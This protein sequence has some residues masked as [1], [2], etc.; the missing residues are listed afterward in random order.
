M[1]KRS[2]RRPTKE[3]SPKLKSAE[4]DSNQ[5]LS[6]CQR[7]RDSMSNL[8]KSI[9]ITKLKLTTL[10]Y[11]SLVEGDTKKEDKSSKCFDQLIEL[12]NLSQ[13]VVELLEQLHLK[14]SESSEN[15]IQYQIASQQLMYFTSEW[16]DNF[17]PKLNETFELAYNQDLIN[18]QENLAERNKKGALR[19]LDAE[20]TNSV[21]LPGELNAIRTN[22]NLDGGESSK[23][24][25]DA[26]MRLRESMRENERLI[27]AIATNIDYTRA[28]I[29]TIHDSL[30][31]TKLN[32]YMGETNAIEAVK[33]LR[34]SRFYKFVCYLIIA[35]ILL[36]IL[37]ILLRII[38]II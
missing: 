23:R 22:N 25:L 10:A 4:I 30:Q 12:C 15:S 6:L 3:K 27:A 26:L 33:T 5:L 1:V 31:S 37:L 19:K 29:D 18:Y 14:L 35:G 21:L 16:Y 13:H 20:A 2:I 28:T 7:M 32:L 34:E 9:Q 36:I 17:T 8:E 11:I 38:G 24:A